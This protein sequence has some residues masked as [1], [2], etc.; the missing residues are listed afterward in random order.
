[1]N[2]K[3]LGTLST[4]VDALL[5]RNNEQIE[6]LDAALEKELTQALKIMG[7][8]LSSLSEKFVSDYTPLTQKLQLLLEASAVSAEEGEQNV[9]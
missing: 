9:A 8:Q 2:E 6:K 5:N 4:H 7:F 1:L 3:T